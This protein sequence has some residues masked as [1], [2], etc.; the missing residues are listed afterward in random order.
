MAE[1][2]KLPGLKRWCEGIL[3]APRSSR[4]PDGPKSWASVDYNAGTPGGPTRC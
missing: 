2:E 1:T 4:K 3:T